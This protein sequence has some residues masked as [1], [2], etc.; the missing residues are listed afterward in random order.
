[1]RKPPAPHSAA[2]RGRLLGEFLRARRDRCSPSDFALAAG[3]RRRAPGLRREE[4][5]ALCG[6]S[7][8]WY[9]WIEQGRSAGISAVTLGAIARGLKLSRAERAYLFELAARPGARAGTASPRG[10]AADRH[11]LDALLD[12][13]HTPAYVLDRHWDAIAWNREAAEL[14]EGWLARGSPRAP[15]APRTPRTGPVERNLLRYVFLDPQAPAFIADWPERAQRLVAEYRADVAAW[16]D[17][18]ASEA[19]V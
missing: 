6:I 11:R 14:F 19:L 17:D 16:R 4:A 9:T 5:A 8:T 1:M 2:D 7:P 3:P 13:I 15:R 10:A 12:I 18:P